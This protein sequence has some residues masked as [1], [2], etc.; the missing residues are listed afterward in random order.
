LAVS[1]AGYALARIGERTAPGL[2]L[3]ERIGDSVASSSASTCII[4]SFANFDT[5]YAPQYARPLIDT[6]LV[7]NTI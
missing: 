1:S 5:A 7:V 6:P 4:P 3:F 2:T